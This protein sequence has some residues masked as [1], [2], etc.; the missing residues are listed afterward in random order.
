MSGSRETRYSCCNRNRPGASWASIPTVR[1]MLRVMTCLPVLV[2]VTL[3]LGTA[4]AQQ[5]IG[6]YNPADY[7]VGARF[8]ERAP[9]LNG[10]L[11]ESVWLQA[12]PATGFTQREPSEGAPA[13]ERTEV[14]ILYTRQTLYIGARMFD[15]EPERLVVTQ[16][17]RDGRLHQD[18]HFAFVLD[19]FLDRRNAFIFNVNPAGARSDGFITDEGRNVNTDFNVVWEVATS[20]DDEGWTAEIAI[21]L[22]QLRFVSADGEQVWGIN[23]RR[24]IRKNNE[25]VY[26]VPTPRNLGWFGLQRLSNAGTLEGLSGLDQGTNLQVKPYVL[27]GAARDRDLSPDP[28]EPAITTNSVT[29]TGLDI[30]YVPSPNLTLDLTVNTDFAQVEAD[31][32]RVNLSRFS[33]FFPEKRDFFLEGAGI[34]GNGGRGRGM[35]GG[36]GGGG[37]GFG[38]GPDLQ[39]FYSR[40]IGL[41]STGEE[42]PIVGGG[43]LTGRMGP[44]TVGALNVFTSKKTLSDSTFES[45]TAWSVVTL[46][47]NVFERSSVGMLVMNKDPR[48]GDYNRSLRFD[49]NL[50]LNEVTKITGEIARIFDPRI[51]GDALAYSGRFDY[52]TDLYDFNI[53]HRKVGDDFLANEMG[54]VRRIGVKETSGELEWSPRPEVFGIRQIGLTAEGSYL[55]DMGNRLLTREISFRTRFSMENTSNINITLS[56][57]WDLL[58]YDFSIYRDPDSDDVVV[59]PAGPYEW[60]GVNFHGSTDGRKPLRFRG[61]G[62]A[63]TYYNGHRVSGNINVTFQPDPHM[64]VDIGL[65]RN[66]LWNIG[67]TDPAEV[68]DLKSGSVLVRS[69]TTST[70]SFRGQYAFTP[71]LFVKGYIQYNDSRNAI[72]SN[73]LLHWIIRDG[74]EIYLVYNENYETGLKFDPIATDRTLMLKA[75]YLLLW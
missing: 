36:M 19:T 42:V 7:V 37:G 22:S 8:V 46:R 61:G 51:T 56:R 31:Q 49:A 75:T 65:N 64:G 13:T 63:G 28:G 26:W 29:D 9:V 40:R 41:S 52:D 68:D 70:V 25:E 48:S 45:T 27:G 1:H 18:D 32:E 12:R 3:P 55:T 39:L 10:R 35:F 34:F 16:L 2:L 11:D 44:W 69:F 23:F 47:R 53:S 67:T 66:R 74:T 24:T 73:Y 50:A 71:N 17:R 38:G 20:V 60:T 15:S 58:D 57:E 33:L 6:E 14:R 5:G 54:Y 62:S 30:K 4:N 59:I 43:K 72:V 21:P